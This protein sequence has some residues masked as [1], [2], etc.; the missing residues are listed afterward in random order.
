MWR[1]AKA[2]GRATGFACRCR[3]ARTSAGGTKLMRFDALNL[4]KYGNFEGCDLQFPKQEQDFHIIF[5]A[6]EAGKSTTLAAVSDL[7]FGFTHRKAQDYRFDA[8]LLRVGGLLE[9]GLQRT[10]VRRKRGRGATLMDRQDNPLDEAV[11]TSMLHGQTR[12]TFHAAWSLDHRLLREG[13]EGIV[14]ARND[15]GQALFAAGSGLTGVTRIL[16]TL[17]DEGDQIWGAR[18]KASR[19][20]TRANSDLK[21]SLEE[22]RSLFDER[23]LGLVLIGMPGIE[24]RMARYPQLYSRIGFVHEFLPLDA[25]EMRALLH[26][27]WTPQGVTLPPEPVTEEVAAAILRITGGNFRLFNRRLLTQIERILEINGLKQISKAVVEAA[28]Q[29]LVI[30]SC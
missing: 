13:G 18:A 22:L 14:S 19:S 16:E 23:E 30:G 28:R 21:D 6:N 5:G 12:E 15:I 3:P 20:Y 10:Q 25:T 11:L 4:L 8:S 9:H 26:R 24:K 29:S 2:N 1:C 27:R 17:E 7:L